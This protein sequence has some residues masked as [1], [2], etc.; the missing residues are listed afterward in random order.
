MEDGKVW[1]GAKYSYKVWESLH[2]QAN[3]FLENHI[4]RHLLGARVQLLPME[5]ATL[6]ANYFNTM[7]TVSITCSTDASD[8]NTVNRT[9]F[10]LSKLR[11]LRRTHQIDY[12]GER[13]DSRDPATFV[14][15][16]QLKIVL[17]GCGS[18]A[19]RIDNLIFLRRGVCSCDADVCSC[20]ARTYSRVARRG[21]NREP[22]IRVR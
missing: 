5:L 3:H 8:N 22:Y 1:Y 15:H 7:V 17:Q 11:G 4:F 20:V 21:A 2:H 19:T 14:V 13:I 10:L 18:C 12:V 6:R 9:S 16:A